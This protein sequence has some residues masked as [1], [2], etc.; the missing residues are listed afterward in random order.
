MRGPQGPPGPNNVH[1]VKTDVSGNTIGKSDSGTLL[2]N[3]PAYTYF[4]IPNV[5]PSK[6]A[7]TVQATNALQRRPDHDL[8]PA[9]RAYVYANSAP[10]SEIS[11]KHE[12]SRV[13]SSS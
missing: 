13:K 6:C 7:I 3:G 12:R 2:H 1:R 11:S 5:D 8:L 9:V 10:K 4:T